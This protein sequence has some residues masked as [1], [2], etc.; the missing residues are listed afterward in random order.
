MPQT[1]HLEDVIHDV[2]YAVRQLGRSPGFTIVAALT[3]AIG[4]GATTAI[5]SAV[6]AVVLRPLPF[7]EPD[8]LVRIYASSPTTTTSDEASPK[9]FTAWRRES[10]SFER[11]A[12]IE[13]RSFTFADGDQL[14][15]RAVGVRT[16]ADYFPML[17]VPPMLGRTFTAEEDVPGRDRVAVLSHRFWLSRFGGD[18]SVVGR[19]VRLNALPFVMIGVMPPG[20]DVSASNIDLWTPIALTAEE[21][22]NVETGYLDVIARLSPGVTADRAQTELSAITRRIDEG[23]NRLERS[24]RVVAYETDL[25][26]AYRPRLFILL[27]AVALVLL[28]ACVNVA[29]LLLVRGAGRGKEIAIRAALG[30]GRVR[31]IRQLL[32]ESVVLGVIG[33]T[34]GLA[35]AV[36]AL[37]GLEGASAEGVP[38]LDQASIDGVALAFTMVVA[39]ASSM[40]FGLVPAL[41]SGT[42]DLHNVLK[43]GG[44][45]SGSAPSDRVRQ[46]LVVVEVALALVLLVSAG[47][48]IRSAMLLQRVEP[49][50]VAENLWTGAVTLPQAEYSDPQRLTSTFEQIV[51]G[52]QDIPSVQSAAVV[53]VAPFT[54]LR[55]LGLFVPE[56]RPV[57][58]RNTL[59]ANFRLTSPGLFR[60]LGVPVRSGRDFSD[61][62]D[63]S[64]PKVAIV[65]EAFARLAWP[66]EA[67]VG[68]RF[69][70]P[71]DRGTGGPLLR[72]VV[73]VVGD[74]REDGLREERPPAVYYPIRQVSPPLWGAV[75]NSMFLVARTGADPRGITKSVQAVVTGI[76][77][78]LPVFG[79]RSMEERMAELL[80]TAR[81]TTQLLTTLGVV[82]LLL[83]LVGI[84][85]V[86]A[87]VVSLRTR[88]IGVR[89]ALGASPKQVVALVVAQ[90]MRPVLA[91]VA[92]GAVAA[93]GVTSVLSSQ[94]FGVGSTD[95]LTFIAVSAMVAAA[96]ALAAALPARRAARIDPVTVLGA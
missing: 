22:A 85:G 77:R 52:V 66:G 91:G 65:N 17:G 33:A 42:P 69:L 21:A 9:T 39:L 46:G 51:S 25:V 56:G 24:A 15:Q 61:R 47:L 90:G 68:K 41:R 53:S 1:N 63:A 8:Q 81:F 67:A 59:M 37:R 75:Q 57:D 83:A 14:P 72:E 5:F 6:N 35:V 58:D 60:T 44:R 2:R 13:T 50:L 19:T 28:I 84:Y 86:V 76:D 92:L 79:V 54:G 80:A 12:A 36:L 62:D 55:A 88:E 16:T 89:V 11:M 43:Q 3:L 27:G 87:Y 29:N 34:G 71:G 96:A 31:V 26:G 4:I 49:G 70:G 78:G 10:R 18:A 23:A 94:L 30:A 48:L 32:A 38:R 73:G 20:F 74:T 93:A 82:G 7:H 40:I 45:S 95:P 64:A